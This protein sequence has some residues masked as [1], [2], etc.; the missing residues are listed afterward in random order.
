M[1]SFAFVD[2]SVAVIPENN[3]DINDSSIIQPIFSSVGEVNKK[4]C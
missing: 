1:E 3:T 2:N 4:Y